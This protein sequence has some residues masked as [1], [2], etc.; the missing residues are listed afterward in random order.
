MVSPLGQN[1]SSCNATAIVNT[2]VPVNAPT[3]ATTRYLDEDASRFE[4]A[5][6][7]GRLDL[8]RLA[9]VGPKEQ[10]LL[11]EEADGAR[12]VQVLPEQHAPVLAAQ[13]RHL[14]AVRL[15]VRPVQL[16]AQP[17]DGQPVRRHKTC[18]HSQEKR[19]SVRIPFRWST[20]LAS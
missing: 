14:D 9:P 18:S 13:R 15:A 19:P 10:A 12:L 16:V 2:S 20:F 8:G 11:G 4:V 7:A 17:I 6:H 5:V 3:A 1:T